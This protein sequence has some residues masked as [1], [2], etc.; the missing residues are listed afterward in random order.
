MLDIGAQT[1]L[2]D[3]KTLED[4]FD[5]PL[6]CQ[7]N[8]S[9]CAVT[10]VCWIADGQCPN[11]LFEATGRLM[12]DSCHSDIL[13]GKTMIHHNCGHRDFGAVFFPESRSL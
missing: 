10:D 6:F 12:C 7:I 2:E 4:C 13:N 1:S 9:N 3:L 11:C 8:F 5:A